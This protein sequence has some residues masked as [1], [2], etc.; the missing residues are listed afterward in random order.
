METNGLNEVV[1][2]PKRTIKKN[3]WINQHHNAVMAMIAIG[4]LIT[5]VVLALFAYGSLNAVKKQHGLAFKQFVITNTPSIKLYVDKPFSFINNSAWMMLKAVNTGGYIKGLKTKTVLLCCGLE[6]ISQP[7]LI[8]VIV[9][10][11]NS[12]YGLLRNESGTVRVTV[13][14]QDE[15]AWL[16]TAVENSDEELMLYLHATYTIPPVL[17]LTGE[18]KKASTYLLLTWISSAKRFEVVSSAHEKRILGV[19]HDGGYLEDK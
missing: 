5:T 16:K 4:S 8:K 2:E 1:E 19:I 15:L 12:P 14:N 7:D 9:K 6:E 10:S 18:P 11:S 3:S 13:K 17:S